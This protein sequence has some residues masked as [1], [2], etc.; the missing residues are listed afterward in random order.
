MVSITATSE[1]WPQDVM[2]SDVLGSIVPLGLELLANPAICYT[3][4]SFTRPLILHICA[5]G[6]LMPFS[7]V[8]DGSKPKTA[9][10][11]CRLPCLSLPT[12]LSAYS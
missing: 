2:R 8:C 10:L 3:A 1:A 7:A 6:D 4:E 9:F 5:P 11:R 12:Q